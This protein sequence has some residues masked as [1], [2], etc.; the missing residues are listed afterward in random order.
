MPWSVE[1]ALHESADRML[2]ILNNPKEDSLANDEA[3]LKFLGKD[4]EQAK[5]T[6]YLYAVSETS[7]IYD[8]LVEKY[9]RSYLTSKQMHDN[10]FYDLLKMEVG[11]QKFNTMTL[12][13]KHQRRGYWNTRKKV[14]SCIRR[15]IAVYGI[16]IILLAPNRLVPSTINCASIADISSFLNRMIKSKE[17]RVFRE[18]SQKF[19]FVQGWIKGKSPMKHHIA[20]YVSA[21][22]A[23]FRSLRISPPWWADTMRNAILRNATLRTREAMKRIPHEPEQIEEEIL[24]ATEERMEPA[25]KAADS[26]NDSDTAVEEDEGDMFSED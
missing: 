21:V 15:W 16:G 24:A 18:L 10:A 6:K 25:E 2:V 9:Q 22:D 14:G 20:D 13:E 19:G 23:T 1:E 26:D 5:I 8:E 4:K 17:H 7:E 3:V 12:A 11:S